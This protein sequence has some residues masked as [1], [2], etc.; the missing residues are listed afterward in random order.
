MFY[1]LKSIVKVIYCNLLL[2]ANHKKLSILAYFNHF[3]TILFHLRYFKDENWLAHINSHEIKD[4]DL[5]WGKFLLSILTNLITV[6]K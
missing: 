1:Y 2:T 3:Y 5:I 6:S 4:R